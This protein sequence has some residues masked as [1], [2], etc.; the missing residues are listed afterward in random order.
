M[1]GRVRYSEAE[2][3]QPPPARRKGKQF[4]TLSPLHFIFQAKIIGYYV[5]N[6]LRYGGAQYVATGRGLPTERRDFI[7]KPSEQGPGLSLG[8]IPAQRRLR[9]P[10]HPSSIT[11]PRAR[12]QAS[13]QVRAGSRRGSRRLH[14]A[15]EDPSAHK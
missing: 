12:K 8:V 15:H 11:P 3:S 9:A 5:M 14:T 10:H 13:K 7:G 2:R 6:E 1:R 4:L